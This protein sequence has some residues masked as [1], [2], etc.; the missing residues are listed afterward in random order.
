[1]VDDDVQVYVTLAKGELVPE[2]LLFIPINHVPSV[3]NAPE[4]VRDE[5][6]KCASS[7]FVLFGLT[8]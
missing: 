4:A 6:E 5:L 1:M 2:H 7:F 8:R 3:T